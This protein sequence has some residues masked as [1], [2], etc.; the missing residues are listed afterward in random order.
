MEKLKLM[1]REFWEERWVYCAR[2]FWTLAQ[3]EAMILGNNEQD[4]KKARKLIRKM[5]TILQ[6][7][8]FCMKMLG[9]Y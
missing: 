2:R 6:A 7:E 4:R 1:W 5:W 8:K 9:E 3:D